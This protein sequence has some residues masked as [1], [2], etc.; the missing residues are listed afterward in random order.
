MEMLKEKCMI[1]FMPNEKRVNTARNEDQDQA[2][3]SIQTS[4]VWLR[5]CMRY[6][7]TCLL[8]GRTRQM[9]G[10][11]WRRPMSAQRPFVS[12]SRCHHV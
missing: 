7:P 5:S 12:V 11:I 6:L 3:F 10:W 9:E 4:I 2:A 8:G 1:F